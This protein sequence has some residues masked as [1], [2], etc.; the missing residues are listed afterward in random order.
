MT[1]TEILLIV[2]LVLSGATVLL[3]SIR[4]QSTCCGGK[5]DI[6]PVAKK[7]GT[8]PPVIVP[9][10]VPLKATGEKETV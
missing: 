3:T 8:T 9:T 7:T 4:F 10:E 2:N 5:C 1:P 6:S